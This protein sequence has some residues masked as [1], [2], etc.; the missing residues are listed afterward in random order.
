MNDS[1]LRIGVAGLGR[2]GWRFHCKNLAAHS[3]FELVAVA[4]T[5]PARVEEA[6]DTYG[7][8]GYRD[9]TRMLDANTL[10][11]VVIATPTHL[12]E[13]M[14]LSA[15]ERGLHVLLEKPMALDYSQSKHLV[16][17]AEAS[18]LV[19]T[20]YQPH[21]LNCYF[22]HLKTL[23][24][25]GRIGRLTRVQ[26]GSFSY[27]RRNDWQSLLKYGG[28]ML[29]NYGAHFLDQILQ[30]VGYDITRVCCHLQRVA[31]LGDADDVVDV[32]L[33]TGA[34]VIGQLLI[35]QA[36]VIRPYEFVVW[37][38]QGGIEL[39]SNQFTIRSFDADALPDKSVDPSLG[40]RD[41][42]YPSDAME[43]EE[44]T[45]PVDQRFGIDVFANFAAAVRGEAALAVP[46]RETLA[47]MEILDRCRESAGGIRSLG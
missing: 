9:F 38:T 30:L 16:E 42:K 2:I 47:L 34:G 25:S 22:Q 17:Q 18:D 35:S 1:A 7:C 20:V 14:T 23:I 3:E 15:F 27:S 19:L 45:V 12:H 24:D 5:D 4:D 36:S 8:N 21:R 33:E 31:S 32:V 43:I 6:R 37:G 29:S 10:D 13:A 11:A 41:R 26:R 39:S 44:E 46:P 40:S 28:G